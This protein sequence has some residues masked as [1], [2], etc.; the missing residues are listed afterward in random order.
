MNSKI[1]GWKMWWDTGYL[2]SQIVSPQRTYYIT[3]G[4]IALED[5]IFAERPQ[6]TSLI[7]G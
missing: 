1:S 6:L 4:K 3:K 5:T 7:V 2:Q